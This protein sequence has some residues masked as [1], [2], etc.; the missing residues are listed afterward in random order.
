MKKALQIPHL[1]APRILAKR[2]VVIAARKACGCGF[3]DHFAQLFVT[4]LSRERFSSR[5]VLRARPRRGLP[6]RLGTVFGGLR[7]GSGRERQATRCAVTEAAA[8]LFGAG[9]Q[10]EGP[11][12]ILRV[13]VQRSVSRQTRGP[14]VPGDLWP[15]RADPLLDDR[16]H[17]R[18]GP[19]AAEL[20]GDRVPDAFHQAARTS[21]EATSSSC[22]GSTGRADASVAVMSVWPDPSTRSASTRRRPGSSSDRTSSSKSSGANPRRSAISEASASRSASTVRRCSP[23]EPKLRRSRGPLV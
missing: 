8:D 14:G 20:P 23:W 19:E 1:R 7:Q 9:R 22:A 11:D 10:L 4:N 18:G 16:R 5:N 21:P 2:A 12:R 6:D 17:P 15:Y 13:D 3:C